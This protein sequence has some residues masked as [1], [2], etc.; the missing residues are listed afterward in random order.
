VSLVLRWQ[1]REITLSRRTETDL[2]ETLLERAPLDAPI[3]PRKLVREGERRELAEALSGLRAQ[4]P[5]E[6]AAVELAVPRDWGVKLIISHPGLEGSDLDR[7]L[8]WELSKALLDPV[9][10]YRYAHRTDKGIIIHLVALRNAVIEAAA[11]AAREAGFRPVGLFLEDCLYEELDLLPP[12]LRQ[13]APPA[14]AEAPP[15][16]APAPPPEPAALEPAEPEP[17]AE[18]FMT[19]PPPEEEPAESSADWEEATASVEELLPPEHRGSSRTFALVAVAAVILLGLFVVLRLTGRQTTPPPA[20]SPP[21]ASLS[22]AETP[23]VPEE[24]LPADSL[25]P[26][27]DE[28]AP[29][30]STE[31]ASTEPLRAARPDA[32]SPAALPQRLAVAHEC[33]NSAGPATFDLLSFTVD[34]FLFQVSAPDSATLYGLLAQIE[35]QPGVREARLKRSN[36]AGTRAGG[37]ITGKLSAVSAASA[38]PDSEAVALLAEKHDLQRRAMVFTGAPQATLDFLQDMAERDYAIYRVIMTPW[39]GGKYR[40]M[41]DF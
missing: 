32:S 22:P 24:S 19:E 8:E 10:R 3:S 25:N 6:D 11:Q 30:P 2:A 31:L 29:A 9:D 17:E 7:H 21:E 26:A 13:P 34:R 16:V 27:G 4:A 37:T 20:V 33:L 35:A 36:F 14:A 39:E 12:S 18:P 23:A 1:P 41:L 15:P 5:E 28:T 38:P 40:T